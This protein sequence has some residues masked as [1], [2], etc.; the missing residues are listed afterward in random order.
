M[1]CWGSGVWGVWAGGGGVR[2][3]VIQAG[4]NI[5]ELHPSPRCP[6]PTHHTHTHTHTCPQVY[7]PDCSMTSICKE[8]IDWVKSFDK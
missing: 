6:P 5:D 8:G 4:S 1:C 2:V 7:G 3:C